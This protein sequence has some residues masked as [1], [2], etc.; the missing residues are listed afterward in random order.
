MHKKCCTY[1]CR[2]RTN[3]TEAQ[4]VGV[5]FFQLANQQ[6]TRIYYFLR[7]DIQPVTRFYDILVR[8]SN[9]HGDED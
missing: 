1:P 9:T 5:S 7:T 4:F 3:V 8:I 6:N 2:A